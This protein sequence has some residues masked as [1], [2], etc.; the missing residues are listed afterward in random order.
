MHAI[1]TTIPCTLLRFETTEEHANR[2]IAGKV[3]FGRLE[4]YRTI[5][6]LRN[7]QME[8]RASFEWNQKAPRIHIENGKIVGQG[9]SDQ[10]LRYTGS[11]LN[12][13]FILC[14]SHP[15][16]DV[17]ALAE[18][19]GQFMVRIN[20]P[21]ALLERIKAVWK[22]HPWALDN[23]SAFIA[24][25]KYN[26]GEVIPP[27]RYL[28]APPQYSYYQKPKLHDDEMEFRYVLKC[29]VAVRQ[30]PEDYLTLKLPD[31]SDILTLERGPAHSAQS[32]I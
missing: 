25:V 17:R 2:L 14:T 31:C 22:A 15:D 26:K 12:P 18:K 6:G 21:L 19:F 4:H 24:R 20:D 16:A 5:E 9:Q 30:T 7:D 1:G 3:R 10:N 27:D 29:K 8:G 32:D 11:S 28:I 13:Y 23:N